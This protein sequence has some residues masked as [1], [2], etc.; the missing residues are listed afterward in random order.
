MN[1]KRQLFL[2][3]I[4]TSLRMYAMYDLIEVL[5]ENEDLSKE[6]SAQN[7]RVPVRQI[8]EEIKEHL[9]PHYLSRLQSRVDGMMISRYGMVSGLFLYGFAS[10]LTFSDSRDSAE[11]DVETSSDKKTS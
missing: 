1:H 7:K 6:T 11:L 10:C 8:P 5:I 2:V 4:C 3:L 9:H